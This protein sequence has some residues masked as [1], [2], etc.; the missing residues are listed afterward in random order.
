MQPQR[1]FEDHQVAYGA[2]SEETK[3]VHALAFVKLN[4]A[5]LKRDL[6]R[7]NIVM[8]YAD[9]PKVIFIVV[10]R[11][12]LE[13]LV[14]RRCLQVKIR[15]NNRNSTRQMQPLT[16]YLVLRHAAGI[17]SS[18]PSFTFR[19]LSGRLIRERGPW[20][21]NRKLYSRDGPGL[22]SHRRIL[23]CAKRRKRV[24]VQTTCVGYQSTYHW[25]GKRD[26]SKG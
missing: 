26:H 21:R 24:R 23:G 5:K 2:S 3:T 17:G 13:L 7:Q 22:G 4:G 8:E 15:T 11:R 18:P 19:L 6:L 25:K 20:T 10:V 1:A 12:P 14:V 9:L 16:T